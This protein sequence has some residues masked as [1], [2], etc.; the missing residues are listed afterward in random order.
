MSGVNSN[1][2]PTATVYIDQGRQTTPYPLGSLVASVPSN[3]KAWP[4]LG[5]RYTSVGGGGG[6]YTELSRADDCHGLSHGGPRCA[7]R[8]GG[9]G[10]LCT[11]V[12]INTTHETVRGGGKNYT[13]GTVFCVLA[14]IK[15]LDHEEGITIFIINGDVQLSHTVWQFH[16]LIS[17]I[18]R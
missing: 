14:I 13:T 8:L 2:S 10:S 17:C 9:G 7:Q 18:L 16:V 15:T 1:T 6:L 4:S 3:T 5:V 11:T 12:D